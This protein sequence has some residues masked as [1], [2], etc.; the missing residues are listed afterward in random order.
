MTEEKKIV[1]LNDEH[2]NKVN[3]GS[4]GVDLKNAKERK[5]RETSLLESKVPNFKVGKTFKEAIK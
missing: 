1:E 5:G 3:G 2:L 4:T